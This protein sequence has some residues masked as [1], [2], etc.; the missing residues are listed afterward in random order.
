MLVADALPRRADV[1]VV[2]A[3]VFGAATA[4]HLAEAG[5]D[6]VVVERGDF[7][8]EASGA[9]VGLVSLSP[10]PPGLM[11]DLCRHATDLYE[12]LIERLGREVY[13]Q[14][15]GVI[16]VGM[17]EESLA[18]VIDWAEC[19]RSVGI[20]VEVLSGD[21]LRELEPLLPEGVLGGCHTPRGGFVS[22][23]AVV[24][25]YLERARELGAKLVPM[26][27]VT[28]IT[29]RGGRVVSVETTRGRIETETVVNAAG[30]W[31]GE[32]SAMVG[33][34]TPVI[35][36]RGQ[37]LVTEPLTC[38]PRRVVMGISPSIRSTWAANGI[39]GSIQEDA[40][41]EKRVTLAVMRDFAR[42]ITEM[43]PH[44]RHVQVIRAWSGLRPKTPDR[45]LILGQTHQV[46]GFVVSTGGFDIGMMLGPAVGEVVADV[47]LER[48]PRFDLT[49]ARPDRFA[50]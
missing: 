6:A 32:V 36:I 13:F 9:N 12:S 16:R 25:G 18:D 40:G 46:R 34:H 41:F 14:P 39:I 31:A 10:R 21:K 49:P 3:G 2:G 35:P 27:T 19:Q 5:V 45:M 4:F 30:A 50:A 29:V 24:A 15:T 26:T 7:C 23:F 28:G 1:V 42:G 22:P 48:T 37:V 44:L 17:T 20:E 33:L 8:S 47:V 11:A 43:Y 38:L